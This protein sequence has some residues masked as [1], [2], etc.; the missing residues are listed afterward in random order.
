MSDDKPHPENLAAS[1]L[2]DIDRLEDELGREQ[3][4][5]L[6]DFFRTIAAEQEARMTAA[7]YAATGELPEGEAYS[8]IRKGFWQIH[9]EARDIESVLRSCKT[10]ERSGAL[11][12]IEGARKAREVSATASRKGAAG[13]AAR[14]SGNEGRDALDKMIRTLAYRDGDPKEL[15]TE[16]F[17]MMD[18]SSGDL[19]FAP[20]EKCAEGH[21]PDKI[22]RK[23]RIESPWLPDPLTFDTFRKRIERARN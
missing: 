13:A 15:W 2:R 3:L 22:C 20:D 17:S 5:K 12:P 10:L 18:D 1:T 16:L 4:E 21:A 11:T 19:D 23:C 7:W 8:I 9:R 6:S 14:W